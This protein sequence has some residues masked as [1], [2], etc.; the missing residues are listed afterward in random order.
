MKVSNKRKVQSLKTFSTFICFS[1]CYVCV[2]SYQKRLF[3]EQG[4]NKSII[5]RSDLSWIGVFCWHTDKVVSCHLDFHYFLV[6]EESDSWT[7]FFVLDSQDYILFLL[8]LALQ[9]FANSLQHFKA[10]FFLASLSYFLPLFHPSFP[11]YLF[12]SF[13]VLI[14]RQ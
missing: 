2:I 14:I 1:C 10:G 8:G 5:F 13:S 6:K 9:G 4:L 12:L 3:C 7:F 11:D